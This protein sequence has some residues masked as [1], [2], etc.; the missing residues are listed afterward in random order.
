M[1][2]EKNQWNTKVLAV[3]KELSKPRYR[4]IM[5]AITIGFFIFV[6]IGPIIN[7]FSTVFVSWDEIQSS[8]FNDSLTGDLQWQIM[9]TALI[10]SFCIAGLAVVID[11]IIGLPMAILLTRFEFRGKNFLD[12]M[13]DLP[14]AIPTSALGFSV[15]LFWGSPSGIAGLFGL[16]V[17]FFSPGPMLILITHVIFTYPFIVRSLKIV[18][19]ETPKVY[20]DAATTLGAPGFTVFRTITSPLVKEGIIAGVILAFARS[21]GE[22]GA[23]I[24]VAGLYETAPLVIVKMRRAL[25][26]PAA[27]FLSMILIGICLVLLATIKF[28]SRRVGFP[29]KKIW[30]T[31]ERFLSKPFFRK[32]RNILAVVIFIVFIF[33]TSMF[34]LTYVFQPQDPPLWEEL[35]GADLKWAYLWTSLM[36]SFLI[37]GVTTLI[38]MATG[39]PMAFIIVNRKWK[40]VNSLLDTLIDIP[41]AIPSAALGFATFMF[42]GPPGLN[43]FFPGFWLI[44]WVHVAFTFPYMIRPV[45]SIIQKSNKGLEDA[46]R[47][48]GASNLTTFRRITLPII[49]NG[50]LAGAIMAFARSLGETGATLVVMGDVRTI[51]VIIVDW[52]E[53][54][55]MGSA[56]FASVIIILF[57]FVLL[58]ILR[59]VSKP[60]RVLNA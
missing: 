29:L 28:L 3:E 58:L 60:R 32:A 4:K 59:Y 33:I 27:A 30:P 44:V 37:G 45:I 50:I 54:Q 35:Y 9:G 14:L 21:L 55:A 40:K 1:R 17:G 6:I 19:Q 41:L 42:W 2:Q 39:I 5:D 10:R 7:I 47:T 16:D 48:L 38:V 26:I 12:A 36:N 24:I 22:T 51:P 56:A 53:A 13:V 52:V 15:Y 8:V 20:E 43:I 25:D 57:A 34:I 18:L 11:L 49:K 31:G 23:T 46:S